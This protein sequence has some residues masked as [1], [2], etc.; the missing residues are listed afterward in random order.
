MSFC[1][2][3][4]RCIPVKTGLACSG[5]KI[6]KLAL[7][8]AIFYSLIIQKALK[9]HQKAAQAHCQNLGSDYFEPHTAITPDCLR[10]ST[11]PHPMPALNAGLDQRKHQ[12]PKN[13]NQKE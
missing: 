8:I 6:G 12:N 7:F 1:N 3:C 13:P 2:S 4:E 5:D 11:Y 10:Y 9:H